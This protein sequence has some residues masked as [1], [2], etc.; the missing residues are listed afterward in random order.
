MPVLWIDIEDN[1]EEPLAVPV[2]PK[3]KVG[4]RLGMNGPVKPTKKAVP[5]VVEVIVID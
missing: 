1:S 4:K 2:P 5:D 3:R